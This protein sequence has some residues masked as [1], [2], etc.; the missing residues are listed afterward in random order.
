MMADVHI[1]CLTGSLL[2][3]KEIKIKIKETKIKASTRNKGNV[4]ERNKIKI[5]E[6][7]QNKKRKRKTKYLEEKQKFRRKRKFLEGSQE[8]KTKFWKKSK[9]K[10]L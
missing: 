1:N 6:R 10:I 2:I 3:Q 8:V 4:L 5:L 9:M 7:Q